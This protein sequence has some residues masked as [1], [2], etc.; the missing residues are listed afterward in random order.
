MIALA[1]IAILLAIA[2]PVYTDYV[3]KIRRKEAPQALS[4]LMDRLERYALASVPHACS[5]WVKSRRSA[6]SHRH[7]Y[8]LCQY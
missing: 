1:V 4:V 2:Y 7:I 6:G 5:L 3:F 8:P